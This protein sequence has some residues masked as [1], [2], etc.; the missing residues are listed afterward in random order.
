M[1]RQTSIDASGIINLVNSNKNGNRSKTFRASTKRRDAD[2]LNCLLVKVRNI[3]PRQYD[4]GQRNFLTENFLR[5]DRTNH[6]SIQ[7][8]VHRSSVSVVG[9]SVWWWCRAKI[10]SLIRSLLNSFDSASISAFDL[11]EIHREFSVSP[12]F[13]FITAEKKKKKNKSIYQT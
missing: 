13:T 7:E 3:F 1:W 5:C 11:P 12:V 2:L 8:N 4:S 10:V 9:K 6:I